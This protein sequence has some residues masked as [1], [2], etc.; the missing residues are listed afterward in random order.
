M[1]TADEECML[2]EAIAGGDREARTRMI[3][4]NLGLVATIAR[5]YLGR[6]MVF[7]DLIGEGNLG[8]IRAAQEFDP[9]FGTRFCT[10]AR[11]LIKQAIRDALINTTATIRLPAHVVGLLAKWRR[12]ERA[13]SRQQQGC[14]PSFSEVASF[15]GLSEA[16]KSLVAKAHH[17][18][19]L[20]LES[21]V[22]ADTG[23]S[24][25]VDASTCCESPGASLEADDERRILLNRM[26]RLDDR[27][28][29]I[30]ALRYGLEGESALT[31]KE[32]ARRLGINRE[33]VRLIALRA[34]HKLGNRAV[35]SPLRRAGKCNRAAIS[36]PAQGQRSI[37]QLSTPLQ[38]R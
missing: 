11:Y 33:S 8:L 25:S 31:V 9:R 24:S 13:L 15:L 34:M 1:L 35:D 19:E 37:S 18:R 23:S 29:A 38:S 22:D 36:A 6:G 10:Y 16:Q 3:Q 12:A 26:D 17:A 21:S 27:E 2:A 7:D 30:L 14:S 4:A 20:K 5:D 32:T 28:R